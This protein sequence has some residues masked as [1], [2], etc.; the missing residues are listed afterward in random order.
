MTR[1]FREKTLSSSSEKTVDLAID[2]RESSDVVVKILTM[3]CALRFATQGACFRE[4]CRYA[5]DA[6]EG[7]AVPTQTTQPVCRDYQNGRCFRASCRFYHGSNAEQVAVQLGAGNRMFPGSINGAQ[8]MYGAATGD[9]LHNKNPQLHMMNRTMNLPMN[10][11][12]NPDP[13]A[14]LGADASAAALLGGNLSL[15]Q[16]LFLQTAMANGTAYDNNAAL[17]AVAMANEI[18]RRNAAGQQ[19]PNGN[20]D[21]SSMYAQQMATVVAQQQA[22]L[23]QQM[24]AANGQLTN[25]G[26]APLNNGEK[27]SKDAG[28][29]GAYQQAVA[30]ASAAMN[31][32]SAPGEQFSWTGIEYATNGVHQQNQFKPVDSVAAL[33]DSLVDNDLFGFVN[34]EMSNAAA[35]FVPGS[36]LGNLQ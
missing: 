33:P 23:A 2:R 25:G 20:Y 17:T 11:V 21:M 4:N 36:A 34:S 31:N 10:M 6:A 8:G 27:L 14:L 16:A 9:L 12:G 30:A 1:R 19:A 29:G 32:P 3:V 18:L 13:A 24:A 7:A 5:H 15:E 35:A 28:V 22:A 26:F